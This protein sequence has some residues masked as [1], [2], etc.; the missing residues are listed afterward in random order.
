MLISNVSYCYSCEK[1]TERRLNNS[2]IQCESKIKKGIAMQNFPQ[3][4]FIA[5]NDL[6]YGHIHHLKAMMYHQALITNGKFKLT[7]GGTS[8][9]YFNCKNVTMTGEGAHIIGKIG[10]HLFSKIPD[11]DAVGGITMGADPISAAIV[12]AVYDKG[13]YRVK[14]FSVRKEPKEHGTSAWIEGPIVPKDSVMIVDDVL[15]TGNSIISSI[16]K[17]IAHNLIV[18]CIFILIDREENHALYRIKE[19]ISSDCLVFVATTKS[20]ILEGVY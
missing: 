2:C 18:K 15:T 16:S 5:D 6:H 17:C 14:Q 4:K 10:L 7:S 1:I 20:Q 12:N 8:Q 11:M 13:F 3:F 19:Y 9:Q